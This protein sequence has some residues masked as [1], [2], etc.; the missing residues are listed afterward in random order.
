[1]LNSRLILNLVPKKFREFLELYMCFWQEGWNHYSQHRVSAEVK[2]EK[3]RLLEKAMRRRYTVTSTKL[4][5]LQKLFVQ[6]NI[7]LYLLLDMLPAWRYLAQNREIY[8]EMQISEILS[9]SSSPLARLIMVLNDQSPDSYM[10]MQSMIVT[11]MWIMLTEKELNVGSRI[12]ISSRQK[13]SHIKGG[14]K[15]AAVLLQIVSSKRLKFKLAFLYNTLSI[16]ADHKHRGLTPLDVLK[17]FLY[18][19]I[20]FLWIKKRT[21]LVQKGI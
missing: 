1:M 16:Y 18:S 13:I 6:E 7:S 14:L 20:Q 17:I 15:N 19:V 8:D 9:S 12:K 4:A 21:T 3:L 2:K 11:L 10:P 5:R